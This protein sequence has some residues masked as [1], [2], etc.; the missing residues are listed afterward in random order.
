MSTKTHEFS[1]CL[2][3]LCEALLLD[4][5]KIFQFKKDFL[6]VVAVFY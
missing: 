6:G 2:P 1:M 3:T 5:L 4:H